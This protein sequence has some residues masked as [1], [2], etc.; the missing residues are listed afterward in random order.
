MREKAKPKAQAGAVSLSAAG[1]GLVL[2]PIVMSDIWVH[3]GLEGRA[4]VQVLAI[5]VK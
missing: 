4:L 3:I 1:L 2:T 5:A